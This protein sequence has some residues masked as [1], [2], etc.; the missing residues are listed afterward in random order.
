MATLSQQAQQ[1]AKS[2]VKKV[3]SHI[4][5]SQALLFGSAAR[6]TMHQDSDIDLIVLSDDFKYMDLADR[7]MMLS[8]LRGR[9][10]ISWPMDILGYTPEEFEKLISVSSMFAEAK[11]QGIIIT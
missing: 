10:F 4:V 1:I 9:E 6:E 2:Y 3:R 7:L 11:K 5:V 8:R